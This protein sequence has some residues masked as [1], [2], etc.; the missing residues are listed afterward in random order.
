MATVA[1]AATVER[2]TGDR[3]DWPIW[4]ARF[5]SALDEAG[6]LDLADGEEKRPAAG[7]DVTVDPL[8][9]MSG[10]ARDHWRRKNRKLFS[11][12]QRALD[13]DLMMIVTG[14]VDDG[15]GHGAYVELVRLNKATTTASL[16]QRHPAAAA[17]AA[18][19]R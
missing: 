13:D 11:T 12:V 4:H 2:F 18:G 9:R 6:L 17:A 15:D 16:M 7:G 10:T 1:V 19:G 14:A 8:T 5:R 3:E